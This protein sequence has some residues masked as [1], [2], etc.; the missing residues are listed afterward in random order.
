[1]VWLLA[2]AAWVMPARRSPSAHDGSARNT[3]FLPTGVWRV[4]SGHSKLT[5]TASASRKAALTPS[6][7]LSTPL[8]SIHGRT[9]RSSNTSPVK[10]MSS[11][12][13]LGCCR[14]QA[15]SRPRRAQS[16][17][18]VLS[19]PSYKRGFRPRRAVVAGSRGESIPEGRVPCR[20][21]VFAAI[22]RLSAVHPRA[23]RTHS[24][25]T[26]PRG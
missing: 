19:I 4:V 2:R 24:N 17:S 14:Q 1:M 21:A 26:W 7:R 9:P 20:P 15:E 16:Q 25:R 5:T 23:A 3:N 18:A 12:S 6:K 8:R 10:R 13:S 11:V 22:P